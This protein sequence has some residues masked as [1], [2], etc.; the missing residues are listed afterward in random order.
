MQAWG[1]YDIDGRNYEWQT[2]GQAVDI[3]FVMAYDTR[4]Q[5]YGPC[6]ASANSPSSISH[7]GVQQFLDLG[8]PANKIVLGIPWYGYDYP[9][10][11]PVSPTQQ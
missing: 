2:L 9:A 11:T 8:V 3:F 7:L 10:A 6:Q 1:P 5:I 4:S